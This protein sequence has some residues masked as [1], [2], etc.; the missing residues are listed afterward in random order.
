M[1]A[2]P[3]V[4]KKLTIFITSNMVCKIAVSRYLIGFI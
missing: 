2:F 4:N 1:N 3:A